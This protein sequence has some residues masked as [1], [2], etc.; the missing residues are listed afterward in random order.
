MPL[1]ISR[2]SQATHGGELLAA[3]VHVRYGSLAD[4]GQ[5][6]R[7]VRFAPESRH[8][9]RRNR[10]LLLCHKR[11]YRFVLSGAGIGNGPEQDVAI[12]DSADPLQ[13]FWV[14]H[15]A[16]DACQ[17]VEL[18]AIGCFGQQEQEDDIN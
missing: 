6:I 9:R 2:V 12:S 13:Y 7:D 11:T 15:S 1:D 17:C 4:I 5:P 8:V 16:G 18:C 3:F 14:S 10:C